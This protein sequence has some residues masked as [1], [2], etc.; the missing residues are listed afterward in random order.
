MFTRLQRLARDLSG[1]NDELLVGHMLAQVDT[2]LEALELVLDVAGGGRVPG[3]IGEEIADLEDRADD[4]RDD[5][6]R[7]LAAVLAPPID[8]EDMFRLSRSLEDVVSNL[9]DLVREMELFGIHE[10]PLVVPMLEAV[11]EG[12]EELRE[13]IHALVDEPEA[14]TRNAREAKRNRVR[15]GY[16]DGLAELLDGDEA[17]SAEVVKRRQL[18]RRVDVLGLRLGE[19]ADS[20]ADGTVKRN[21]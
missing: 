18:L 5:L 8:R 6:V 3:D 17:V 9:V 10:E 14:S 21:A 1:R 15:H 7:D 12:L 11:V 2:A 13:G 16:Q 19:A 4:H 20:L